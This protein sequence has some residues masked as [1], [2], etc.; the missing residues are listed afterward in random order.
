[1]D[2][3]NKKHGCTFRFA[4]QLAN[5]YSRDNP[6]SSSTKSFDVLFYPWKIYVNQTVWCD[7]AL[8]NKRCAYR[9]KNI[10]EIIWIRRKC[11]ALL[12]WIFSHSVMTRQLTLYILRLKPFRHQRISFVSSFIPVWLSWLCYIQNAPKV[13]FQKLYRVYQTSQ[14]PVILLET[15]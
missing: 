8:C 2:N 5:W 14:Q 12:V 7:Q 3:W 1:M 10:Q 6:N 13:T 15:N 11:G 9:R 4:A